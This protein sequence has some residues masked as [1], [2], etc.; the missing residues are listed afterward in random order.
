MGAQGCLGAQNSCPLGA[1]FLDHR[2]H[3]SQPLDVKGPLGT[4]GPSPLSTHRAQG[5]HSLPH[6]ISNMIKSYN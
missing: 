1:L 4:W 5:I 6:M 3:E 2:G